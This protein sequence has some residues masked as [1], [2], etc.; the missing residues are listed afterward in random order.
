MVVSRYLGAGTRTQVH[1]NCS[2]SL[3][4]PWHAPTWWIQCLHTFSVCVCPHACV[5]VQNGDSF[6]ESHPSLYHAGSREDTQVIHHEAEASRAEPPCQTL[7][8]VT[9]KS[10]RLSSQHPG[11]GSILLRKLPLI[12]PVIFFGFIKLGN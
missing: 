1:W 2:Q 9:T 12:P 10:N 5:P 8:T 7:D 3:S 11:S 6:Q 4:C